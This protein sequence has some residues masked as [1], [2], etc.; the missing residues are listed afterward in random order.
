[1]NYSWGKLV[2]S[3]FS[4]PGVNPGLEIHFQVIIFEGKFKTVDEIL[5]GCCLE[6]EIS[7]VNH[8]SFSH[9]MPSHKHIYLLE[10][11][12]SFSVADL[13]IHID[14][15]VSVIDGHLNWVSGPLGVI[16]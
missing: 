6:L 1:M 13:I 9:D 4:E 3:G 8:D 16:I 10:E 14:C 15:I 12:R 11:A 7:E 5:Q 2:D